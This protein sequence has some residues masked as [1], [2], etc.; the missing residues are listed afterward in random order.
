M[1]VRGHSRSLEMTS[2]DRSNMSSYWR[3]IVTM[4][5]SCIISEIVIVS[6]FHLSLA[7]WLLFSNKSSVQFRDKMRYWSKIAISSYPPA[8]DAPFR[9][10][11][12]EDC[13]NVWNDKTRIVCPPDGENKFGKMFPRFDTIHECDTRTDG[14]TDPARRRTPRYA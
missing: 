12:S 11:P 14:Q 2:F 7:S 8:F 3:S 6:C 10:S 13:R 4:A 1:W 9:D 5:L